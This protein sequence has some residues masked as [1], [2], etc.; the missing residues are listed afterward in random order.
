MTKP[1]VLITGSKGIIGKILIGNLSND[2][3][4]YELDIK[5]GEG[6][7]YFKADVSRYDELDSF[8][9][10]A[11]SVDYIV[12]LAGEPRPDATWESV[13]KNNIIGTRNIYECA[14]QHSV[15]KVIFASSIH[16]TSG[17]TGFSQPVK[18]DRKLPAINV[19]D[20]IRPDSDYGSSKAFGESVARQYFERHGINSICLRFGWVI[21]NNDPTIDEVALNIWL[22]HRDLIQLIKKSI[23]S[24]ISFGIYHG[25]SNN[26]VNFWDISNTKKDLGYEPRDDAFT[27]IHKPSSPMA[28]VCKIKRQVQKIIR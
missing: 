21:E 18:K 27:L 16:V 3:D 5:D 6:H 20:P 24:D 1:S 26:K 7:R 9:K 10:E 12:H 17:Y 4:M 22:S 23:L 14:K 11:G 25:L 13:L 2:F 28:I 19:L 8:F 15:K